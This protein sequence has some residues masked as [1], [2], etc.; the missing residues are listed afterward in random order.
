M[1][2]KIGNFQRQYSNI[3]PKILKQLNDI[4]LEKYVRYIDKNFGKE[5]MRNFISISFFLSSIIPL[6]I[7]HFNQN[8]SC[9]IK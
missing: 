4:N 3:K 7:N 6:S 5:T 8:K 1:K 2:K 9:F